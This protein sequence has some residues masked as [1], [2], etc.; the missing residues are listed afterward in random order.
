T[1]A[2]LGKSDSHAVRIGVALHPQ[3][4]RLFVARFNE[5]Q[6]LIRHAEGLAAGFFSVSNQTGASSRVGRGARSSA[7]NSATGSRPRRS[8]VAT[9]DCSTIRV[10]VPRSER[11]PPLILRA[12]TS[13]RR[14]RSAALFVGGTAGSATKVKSSA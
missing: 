4:R 13:G 12:I 7:K 10:A 8:Q 5:N 9:S 11:V 1:M 2:D 3:A 6:A 14:A